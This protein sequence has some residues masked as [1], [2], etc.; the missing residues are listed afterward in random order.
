MI[1]KQSAPLKRETLF[2][3]WGLIITFTLITGIPHFMKTQKLYKQLISLNP[4]ENI[5]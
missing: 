4:N 2:W 5:L 1:E 3:V